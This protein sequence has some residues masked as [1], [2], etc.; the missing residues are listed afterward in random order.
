MRKTAS[1]GGFRRSRDVRNSASW[2]V[3]RTA[4]RAESVG[5][6]DVPRITVVNNLE[7]HYLETLYRCQHPGNH[8]HPPSSGL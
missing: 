5:K 8:G 3:A 2:R 6:C 4:S 7:H 1:A